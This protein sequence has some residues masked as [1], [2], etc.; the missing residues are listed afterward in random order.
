MDWFLYDRNLRHEGVRR[1]TRFFLCKSFCIALF[2]L[3]VVVHSYIALS[4]DIIPRAAFAKNLFKMYSFLYEGYNLF[5][6]NYIKLGISASDFL[7]YF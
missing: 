5:L 1:L 7:R 2:I 3:F 4:P 6:L